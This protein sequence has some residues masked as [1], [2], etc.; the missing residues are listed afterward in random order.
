MQRSRHSYNQNI[1]VI[2]TEC[3]RF[4]YIDESAASFFLCP[5]EGRKNVWILGCR[6]SERVTAYVKGACNPSQALPSPKPPRDQQYRDPA[7]MEEACAK[8]SST[9]SGHDTTDSSCQQMKTL[10]LTCVCLVVHHFL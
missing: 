6:T 3:R 4:P 7:A 8:S 9:Q 1:P 10:C 5:T 2:L